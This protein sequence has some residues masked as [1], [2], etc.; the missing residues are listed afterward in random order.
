MRAQRLKN[1]SLPDYLPK[2]SKLNDYGFDPHEQ[3]HETYT[4]MGDDINVHD[5]WAVES[6]GPIQDR[7]KE[8]L[9]A[10]DKAIAACRRLLVRAIRDVAEG[11]PPLLTEGASAVHGP[12]SIDAIGPVDGWEAHWQQMDRQRRAGASWNAALAEAA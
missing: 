3:E 2:V 6:M 10:S 4:G 9:G 12:A 5:Q 8:H 7:T 1:Y 11:R